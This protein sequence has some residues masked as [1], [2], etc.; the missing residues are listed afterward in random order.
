M[1][2]INNKI[3]KFVKFLG[4]GVYGATFQYEDIVENKNVTIKFMIN[5]DTYDN[6]DKYLKY[7]LNSYDNKCDSFMSY[8]A[9]YH[10][11]GV[12]DDENYQQ[13]YDLIINNTKYLGNSITYNDNIFFIITKF[14]NGYTSDVIMYEARNKSPDYQ[15][16]LSIK[17]AHDILIALTLLGNKKI[18]HRDIK[19]NNILYDIDNDIFV[20]IDFGNAILVKNV[21]NNDL[22]SLFEYI[23]RYCFI[24]DFDYSLVNKHYDPNELISLTALKILEELYSNFVIYKPTSKD[25]ENFIKR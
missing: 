11:S 25:L 9:C 13:I 14:I 8:I 24:D 22:S 4:Q 2:Y 6:E 23:C 7:I 15:V 16:K 3:Y 20:L 10:E 21:S 18:Q 19:M 1:L 5:R 17:F 12:V